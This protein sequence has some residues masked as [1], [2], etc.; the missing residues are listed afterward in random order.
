MCAREGDKRYV[1]EHLEELVVKAVDEAGGYGMLMGPQ[2]PAAQ[3][4]E[5]RAR[6]LSR[7]NEADPMEL[8]PAFMG[9]EPSPHAL[10]K[11]ADLAMY[12]AKRAGK[13]RSIA[14]GDGPP[15]PTRS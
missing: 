8:Y 1:L 4:E 6:I 10:L 14:A 3:R 15:G 2:S 13:D 9:R 12:E 7:G 5:F 11:R